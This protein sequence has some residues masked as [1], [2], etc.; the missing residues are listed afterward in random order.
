MKLLVLFASFDGQTARIAERIAATIATQGHETTLSSARAPEAWSRIAEHDTVIIGGAIR[1]GRFAPFLETSVRAHAQA[2]AARPNAFFAC[3]SALVR[4]ATARSQPLPRDS[5][6][7]APRMAPRV[8]RASPA[9]C[10]TGDTI[11]SCASSCGSSPQA[12]GDQD[13]SR[14]HEYTDWQAVERFAVQFAA[15]LRLTVAA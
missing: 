2:I 4:L 6:A 12:G 1:Y 15:G 11:R 13:T 8:T 3:R 14:E 7:R 9:R 5:S 10:A